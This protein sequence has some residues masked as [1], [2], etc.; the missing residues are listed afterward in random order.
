MSK[1]QKPA[2]ETSAAKEYDV[3]GNEIIREFPPTK[4]ATESLDGKEEFRIK[5][6]KDGSPTAVPA[7]EFKEPKTSKKATKKEVVEK[8]VQRVERTKTVRK[9]RAKQAF[10]ADPRIVEML[11]RGMKFVDISRALDVHYNIVVKHRKLAGR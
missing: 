5:W 1:K 7:S 2:V 4:Y 11:E 9:A 6:S 10:E 3:R 8:V